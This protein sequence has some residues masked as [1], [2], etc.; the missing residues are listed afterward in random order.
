MAAKCFLSVE[1]MHVASKGLRR[2]QAIE[3]VLRADDDLM[4][5][6][7]GIPFRRHKTGDAL[8]AMLRR[9]PPPGTTSPATGNPIGWAICGRTAGVPGHGQ[10]WLSREGGHPRAEG[11]LGAGAGGIVCPNNDVA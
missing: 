7:T 4:A 5:A 2:A 3:S 6:G 9:R 11:R 1:N 10:R 8:P